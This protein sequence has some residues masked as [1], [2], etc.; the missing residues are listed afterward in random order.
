MRTQLSRR[1]GKAAAYGPDAGRRAAWKAGA[2]RR[3]SAPSTSMATAITPLLLL[4]PR[5]RKEVARLGAAVLASEIVTH[6]RRGVETLGIGKGTSRNDR[7]PRLFLRAEFGGFLAALRSV[8]D[9]L[10][11]GGRTVIIAGTLFVQDAADGVPIVVFGASDV[12]VGR[13]SI[14]RRRGRARGRRVFR[15]DGRRK[16]ACRVRR[17]ACSRPETWSSPASA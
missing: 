1:R 11:I 15:R 10:S 3:L 13:S 6:F 2:A 9:G 7:L 4:C 12:A 8:R 17:R 5:D 16:P 14:Y